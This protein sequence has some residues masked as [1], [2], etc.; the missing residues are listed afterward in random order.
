[1]IT[2]VL[3]P[4]IPGATVQSRQ[5]P[6]VTMAVESLGAGDT[7]LLVH[8][9]PHTRA[10]WRDVA[11]ALADA[12]LRV[13]VPDLRG[14]GDSERTTGGYDAISLADDLEGLLRSADTQ[15]AHVV[16]LDV[17]VAPAFALAA[18]RPDRVA[19][20]TLMES[21][22]GRLPGAEA[23]LS[24]GP[25]WWFGF[26]QAAN[27]LAEDVLAGAEDRYLRYFLDA[28]TVTG[29]PADLAEVI[30]EA[31]RGRDSLHAAFEHYRA[32]P[33]NAAWVDAWARSGRLPMPVTTLGGGVVGDATGNQLTPFAD[34]LDARL[35]PEAGHILPIDAPEQVTAAILDGIRRAS[36]R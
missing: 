14:L 16:A 2:P 9:F 24:A 20:L 31:Y 34:L 11:P 25:P 36:P 1:M 4:H 13:L 8:G 22:I 17:G 33:Q 27:G 21:L 28:G 23:F 6:G 7:V 3:R 5:L 19:S 15:R 29:F 26:H 12:G 32:L 10:I 30:I 35:I 18:S